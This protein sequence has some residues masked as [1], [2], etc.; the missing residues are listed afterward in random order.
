MTLSEL[1]DLAQILGSLGVILSL[2]F[3]A[4]ELRKNT[5]Q[6]RLANYGD[7]VD[8]FI[9][10]YGMT[11]D[12]ELARLIAK[13]RKS[14]V[15]LADDEKISFGHYLEN[16]CIALETLLH[17]DRSVVHRIGESSSLFNKHLRYHLGFTGS[18][19]WFD[20]FERE[21]GFPAPFMKAI[22]AALDEDP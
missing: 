7:M 16:V 10:V 21:R 3:V 6:S 20:A 4:L 12:L 11:T 13:G 17:Y 22:H 19:E 8:R 1:S 9:S 15:N 18:R 2:I 5:A 14:Y